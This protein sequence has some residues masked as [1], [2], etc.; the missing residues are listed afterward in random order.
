[1]DT[2]ADDLPAALADADVVVL[3][4]PHAVYE[5]IESVVSQRAPADAEVYDIWGFLDPD[6][7][8]QAYDGFGINDPDA[9]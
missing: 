8:D 7:L 6:A 1:V 3:G 5:G 2:V 4:V 9:E